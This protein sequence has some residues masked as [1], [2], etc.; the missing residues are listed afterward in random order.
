M[1]PA[2]ICVCLRH[3]CVAERHISARL[4][5]RIERMLV[6]SPSESAWN[7][8]WDTDRDADTE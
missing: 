6:A 3:G 7:A 1:L 2:P 4:I 8:D 5:D